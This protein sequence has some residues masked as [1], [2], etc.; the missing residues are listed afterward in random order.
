[1]INLG[2]R[3]IRFARYMLTLGLAFFKISL[4]V[5]ANDLIIDTKFAVP[6]HPSF[7][8]NTAQ[9]LFCADASGGFPGE[10]YTLFYYNRK[11]TIE[12][13]R[14]AIMLP[15]NLSLRKAGLNGAYTDQ[16]GV[17]HKQGADNLIQYDHFCCSFNNGC[18]LMDP[19]LTIGTTLDYLNSLVGVKTRVGATA[20]SLLDNTPFVSGSGSLLTNCHNKNCLPT[21]LAYPHRYAR[22]DR[23]EVLFGNLYGNTPDAIYRSDGYVFLSGRNNLDMKSNLPTIEAESVS[24]KKVDFTKTNFEIPKALPPPNFLCPWIL[25]KYL[26]GNP[27]ATN[28][29]NAIVSIFNDWNPDLINPHT[30]GFP[31]YDKNGTARGYG[32]IL[33]MMRATAAWNWPNMTTRGQSFRSVAIQVAS[34]FDGLVQ[35]DGSIVTSYGIDKTRGPEQI[36][37]YLCSADP[38]LPGNFGFKNQNYKWNWSFGDGSPHSSLQ[39]PTHTYHAN[40]ATAYPVIVTVSDQHHNSASKKFNLTIKG[41]SMT[42]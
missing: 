32:F 28:V 27:D 6:E 13:V 8:G 31:N 21:D 24:N 10:D 7:T 35:N 25:L 37:M 14:A 42:E 12:L 22:N 5:M 19:C 30:G 33:H 36:G 38:R 29:R 41:S 3:K 11:N 17:V 23:R 20:R 18:T 39:N 16:A 9:V 4:S 15:V 34:A 1:M 2:Y 40:V 26:R